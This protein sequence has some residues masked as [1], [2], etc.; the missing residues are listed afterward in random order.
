L[1]KPRGSINP[2]SESISEGRPV[3]SFAP[4]EETA[5]GVLCGIAGRGECLIVAA[6]TYLN[7]DGVVDRFEAEHELAFG[8]DSRRWWAE[9]EH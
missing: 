7:R 9:H 6:V 3:I 2:G 1:L 4:D 8:G 5:A